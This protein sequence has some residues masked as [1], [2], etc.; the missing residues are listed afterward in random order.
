M[1]KLAQ[2]LEQLPG[3]TLTALTK[4]SLNIIS[5]VR[6]RVS[7]GPAYKYFRLMVCYLIP[8]IKQLAIV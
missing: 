7:R 1:H 6:G 5:G 2:T 3:L 8:Q 4:S